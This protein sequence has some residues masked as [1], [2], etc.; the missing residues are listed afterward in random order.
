MLVVMA[1]SACSHPDDA[2]SDSPDAPLADADWIGTVANEGFGSRVAFAGGR[3]VVAAPFGGHVY[4]DG[5]LAMTG[6]VDERLGTGLAVR[7]DG[8]VLV[9]APG[10]GA[11]RT[12]D[13]TQVAS[14][15]GLG[16]V[17]AANGERWAA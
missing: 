8:D 17:V 14:G 2:P 6:T 10:A 12:L 3:A 1:L 5:D 15:P 11:L 7:A 4:V 16:G 9:G 13:G